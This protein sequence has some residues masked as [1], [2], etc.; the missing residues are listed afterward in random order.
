MVSHY[1]SLKIVTTITTVY[2][3]LKQAQLRYAKFYNNAISKLS[4]DK[5][6]SVHRTYFKFSADI[7][8]AHFKI[9]DCE[10]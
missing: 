2:E 7:I 3:L 10:T 8:G 1:S 4:E 9:L 6:T 5:N